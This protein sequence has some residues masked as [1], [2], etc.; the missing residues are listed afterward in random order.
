ML[1][2]AILSRV[3]KRTASFKPFLPKTVQMPMDYG[4]L[5]IEALRQILYNEIA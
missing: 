3:A 5:S 4:H 1:P 2:L